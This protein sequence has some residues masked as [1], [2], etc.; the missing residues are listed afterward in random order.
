M[1]TYLVDFLD[2]LR[3]CIERELKHDEQANA[4]STAL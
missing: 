3:L 4:L 2:Y 1:S